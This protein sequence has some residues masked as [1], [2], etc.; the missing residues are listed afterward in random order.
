MNNYPKLKIPIKQ[1]N[2]KPINVADLRTCSEDFAEAETPEKITE[3][4]RVATKNV[5]FL[6]EMLSIS[7]AVERTN[8]SYEYLRYLC[9]SG[10]VNHIK[11][12]RKY[13]IDS[14]SLAEYIKRG[15]LDQ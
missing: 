3:N 13:M 9:Y 12:G 10:K 7:Q 14:G 15:G 2:N 11:C 1:E 5:H 8:L 4:M 6:P